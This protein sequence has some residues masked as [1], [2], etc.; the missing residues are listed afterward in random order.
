MSLTAIPLYN[1]VTVGSTATPAAPYQATQISPGVNNTIV[2]NAISFNFVMTNGANQAGSNA[3]IVFHWGFSM[4]SYTATNAATLGIISAN[5]INLR[6]P[7]NPN[8]TIDLTHQITYPI[9]GNYLYYWFDAFELTSPA[10]LTVN[11]EV[12]ALANQCYSIT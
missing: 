2:G 3:R 6:F 11:A 10:T 9:L 7:K 5:Q 4:A 8:A 1:A 12:V